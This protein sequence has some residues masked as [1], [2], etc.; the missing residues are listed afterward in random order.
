VLKISSTGSTQVG[1]TLMRQS[2]ETIN[3]LSLEL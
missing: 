2:A 3:R 1:R